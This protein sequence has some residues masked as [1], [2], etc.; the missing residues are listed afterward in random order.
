MKKI[1]EMSIAE[2]MGFKMALFE[3]AKKSGLAEM[4]IEA[5]M[6]SDTLSTFESSVKG[7]VLQHYMVGVMLPSKNDKHDTT[8]FRSTKTPRDTMCMLAEMILDLAKH[9]SKNVGM[10]ME[11]LIDL[12][13]AMLA[14]RARNKGS[15]M[16]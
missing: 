14:E 2:A 7:R 12:T 16:R 11:A 13:S 4:D 1:D 10:M 5:L 6:L 8:V 3:N 9:N 15:D